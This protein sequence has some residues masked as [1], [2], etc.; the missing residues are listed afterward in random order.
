[1]KLPL[2]DPTV[3]APARIPFARGVPSE[4]ALAVD[5]SGLPR[6]LMTPLLDLMAGTESLEALARLGATGQK[7]SQAALDKLEERLTP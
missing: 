4:R 7:V 3:T 2:Y 5:P 6:Q 1:M